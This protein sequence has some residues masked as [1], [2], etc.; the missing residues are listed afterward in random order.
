MAS[1]KRRSNGASNGWSSLV[2]RVKLRPSSRAT[3]KMPGSAHG[4]SADSNA[5]IRT[6][7]SSIV[8]PPVLDHEA[9]RLID[10]HV[11]EFV[12]PF[13]QRR[14]FHPA[15]RPEETAQRHLLGGGALLVPPVAVLDAGLEVIT[16]HPEPRLPGS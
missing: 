15:C 1:W 14:E 16:D 11:V 13:F 6:S 10:S 4:S 7:R 9:A 2:S 5:R 3:R 12:E 8:I